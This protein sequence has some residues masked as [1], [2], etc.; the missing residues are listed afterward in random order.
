MVCTAIGV[1]SSGII[2]SKFRPRPTYLAL[3]N[4]FTEVIDVIGHVAFAFIGC[5][6]N[7]LHGEFSN[8]RR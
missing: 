6:K 8:D 5:A 4:V 1:L 3:W 2:V 7:D